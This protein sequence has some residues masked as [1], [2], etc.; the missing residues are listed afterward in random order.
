[1]IVIATNNGKGYLPTLLNSLED[2]DL[3]RKVVDT[4]STDPEFLRYLETI[5]A[6]R[7]QGG[8]CMGA[9]LYA[10]ENFDRPWYLFL[11][12]SLVVKD[13]QFL[14]RFQE[15]GEAVGWLSFPMAF[16]SASQE[17]YVRSFWPDLA[18]KGC[19][20]PI[21]YATREALSR[22]ELPFPVTIEQA[23]GM[24]RGVSSAFAAAGLPMGF[25]DEYET[26]RMDRDEYATFT[27]FRPKR[28]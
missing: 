27:K 9:Y 20:G 17:A 13:P 5:G 28:P 25:I 11:H 21:F 1:M 22:V 24:E 18:P 16:D 23:H 7:T 19:F 8:W 4:G 12:D 26:T 2:C 3:E 14:K 15:I 6:E 10:L